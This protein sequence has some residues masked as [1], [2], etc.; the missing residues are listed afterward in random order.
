MRHE[1]TEGATSGR[2]RSTPSETKT[3]PQL[4]SDLASAIEQAIIKHNIKL[5]PGVKSELVIAVPDE[6]GGQLSDVVLPGG[7]N[8]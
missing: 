5:D 4:Q 6:L 2:S 8:C 3:N 1:P 7:T